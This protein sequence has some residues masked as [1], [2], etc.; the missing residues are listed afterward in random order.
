MMRRILFAATALVAAVAAVAVL[1]VGAGKVDAQVAPAANPGG[2][3]S[4]WTGYAI[5][6]NGSAS[7]GYSLS[8]QWSFG[9]GAVAAGP[10]VSH[11]YAASGAYTVVLTVTDAFGQVSS[12]ATSATVSH[13]TATGLWPFIGGLPVGGVSTSIPGVV[14]VQTAAGIVCGSV[15]NIVSGQQWATITPPAVTQPANGPLLCTLPD[16]INDPRCR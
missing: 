4:G 7:S 1:G 6:F 12:V 3:Y 10:V 9:D 14:C 15:A 11:T 5:Q 2:P 13:V 16:L 8:Y